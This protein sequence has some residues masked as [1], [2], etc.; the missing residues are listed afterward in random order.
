MR[1]ESS[2]LYISSWIFGIVL[3]AI[4][5]LNLFLVHPVPAVGYFL[6]ALL[7]FPLSNN[8]LWNKVSL[9]VQ[10]VVKVVLAIITVL[11]TLGVSDLGEMI[12]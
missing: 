7:Y 10:L 4:G 1:G 12:D 6:L 5:F 3:L 11:F 8:T 9:P 2:T